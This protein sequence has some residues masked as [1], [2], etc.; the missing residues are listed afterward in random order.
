[1]T[2][3]GK[4]D[5]KA[6]PKPERASGTVHAGPVTATEK[7]LVA[8]WQQILRV[9]RVGLHDN[10]FELGGD[11]LNAAEMA[12]HFPTWFDME[13]PLG[14]LFETPTIAALATLI[15]RFRNEQMD[16]LNVVL[17]LRKLDNSE[18]RPVFCIH[19]MI[20]LSIGFSGLLRHLDPKTPVYGLQSRGLRGAV[21]LPGSIEEIAIDYL[22]QIRHIQPEGPYRLI[23]RSMGGLIGHAIAEQMQA[24]GL[25]VELLAMIDS[26]PFMSDGLARLRTE[27]EEVRAA[28]GFLDI[29]LAD[30]NMP[31]TLK[32]LGEFLLH[33]NNM[34]L[35]PMA[36]GA[37]KVAKAMEKSNPAFIQHQSAVMLNN[38]K[39]ARQYVPRKVRLDLLY[40]QATEITGDVDGI[41]DRGP[42]AWRP[43]VAGRIEVHEL[44]CHHEAVLDPIP[45]AQIG[46]VLRQRLSVG[47]NQWV[48]AVSPTVQQETIAISTATLRS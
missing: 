37:M 13:L 11:S 34:R 39:L 8:L 21:S 12:A 35:V 23:G 45:A 47:G 24:H 28:L 48:P 43:F 33:G 44:A 7:R 36:Q 29:H 31:Q 42:S 9:D 1:L 30:D 25:E 14:S 41:L 18:Q 20:G 46:S 22:A 40:F 26:S 19:P 10:F 16:P 5:R 32:N 15:E 3:N 27:A 38:L 2:P 6:L 17:P 4:L